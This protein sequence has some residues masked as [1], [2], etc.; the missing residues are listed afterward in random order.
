MEE[1]SRGALRRSKNS[2]EPEKTCKTSLFLFQTSGCSLLTLPSAAGAF[3][4]FT[5]PVVKRDDR[6]KRAG[7]IALPWAPLSR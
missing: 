4:G 2:S 1:S 7:G 3:A 6:T 5:Q